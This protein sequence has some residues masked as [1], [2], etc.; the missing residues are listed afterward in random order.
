MRGIIIGMMVIFLVIVAIANFVLAAKNY[1]NRKKD[2]LA[3][4]WVKV[5]I[6]SGVFILLIA[7]KTV[8]F[9]FLI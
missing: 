1:K 7:V 3:I 2:P 6:P 4:G 5:Y 8:I 9:E